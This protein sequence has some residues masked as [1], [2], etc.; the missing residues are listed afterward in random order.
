VD[1][2]RRGVVEATTAPCITETVSMLLQWL[3]SF[4]RQD[5]FHLQCTTIYCKFYIFNVLGIV[6]EILIFLVFWFVCNFLLV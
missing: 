6:L 4:V 5:F 1:R 3:F 2:G